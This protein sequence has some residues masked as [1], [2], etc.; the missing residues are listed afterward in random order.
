M[1][2]QLSGDSLSLLRLLLGTWVTQSQI[3]HQKSSW[4]CMGNYTVE[5]NHMIHKTHHPDT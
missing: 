1:K 3:Q 2:V 4:Q 5:E